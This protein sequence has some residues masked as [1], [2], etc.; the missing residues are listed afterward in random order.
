METKKCELGF[1]NLLTMLS[2]CYL[3]IKIKIFYFKGV[4]NDDTSKKVNFLTVT[5]SNG[6]NM[7]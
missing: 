2:S 5:V 6:N 3:L 1:K 7:E 4:H